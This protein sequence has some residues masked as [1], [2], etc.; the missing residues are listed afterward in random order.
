MSLFFDGVYD[1]WSL[2]IPLTSVMCVKE[3][4]LTCNILHPRE[5]PVGSLYCSTHTIGYMALIGP[6]I[7]CDYSL[8]DYVAIIIYTQEEGGGASNTTYQPIKLAKLLTWIVIQVTS[9]L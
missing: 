8:S 4:W 7:M 3:E 5:Q 6:Y 9:E 1:P 2:H